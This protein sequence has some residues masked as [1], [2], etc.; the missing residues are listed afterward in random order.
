MKY[1]DPV[2]RGAVRAILSELDAAP[3]RL[4][5]QNFL[6]DKNARDKI[7]ATAQVNETNSVLEIGP[8]LGALTC[9]LVEV[10]AR[11][12]AIEK[13]RALF[14]YLQRELAAPNLHLVAG[15]ALR[16]A[17]STL[18]LPA[19]NVK[20]VAN[21]PYSISKPFLRRVYEEWRPHLQ[22]ATLMLQKEVAERLVAKP[23]TP[24]YGPLAIMAQLRSETQVA[25]HL[26][27]GAFFP[28]PEI[29]SSVVHIILREQPRVAMS[30][31]KFFWR[32]VKA[33]FAQRR[34]QLANTLRAVV[35]DKGVLT[36]SM[37]ELGINPMR[38]G[39]TLSLEEFARLAE[40]LNPKLHDLP[41][42][43]QD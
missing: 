6:I 10:A 20:V 40:T 30:D 13:D 32:V 18:D 17:W 11:V 36:A 8:G 39:E 24:A 29:A 3:N 25:F 21:L 31:E 5:G 38:R 34:K 35:P 37:N 28:P 23:S 15:D 27:P 2:A 41:Q 7:I 33:A 9:R 1:S 42:S 22:S 26:A 4:L 12:T 16:E 14:E 43:R 19:T